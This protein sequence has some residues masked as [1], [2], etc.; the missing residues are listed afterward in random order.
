MEIIREVKSLNLPEGK[1]VV[2]GSGPLQVHGIRQSSDIDILTTP[3]LYD[4]LKN[5]GWDEGRWEPPY[6]GSYLYRGNF[7][8]VNNWNYGVYNPDPRQLIDTAEIIDGVPFVPLQEVLLWKRAFGREKDKEDIRLI[9][10][11]LSK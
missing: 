11:Y 7:Q 10:E 1:Y 2:F 3:E 8:I 9:E 4:R 6:P 5:Q